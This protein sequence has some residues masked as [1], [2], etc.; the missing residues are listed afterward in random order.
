MVLFTAAHPHQRSTCKVGQNSTLSHLSIVPAALAGAQVRCDLDPLPAACSDG[1]NGNGCRQGL[2]RASD[3]SGVDLPPLQHAW[4]SSTTAGVGTS[5]R[6]RLPRG[7]HRPTGEPSSRSRVNHRPLRGSGSILDARA[8]PPDIRLS[9][10]YLR[11]RR[12]APV[13]RHCRV[14]RLRCRR[15]S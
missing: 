7:H 6:P 10:P 4:L 9:A 11:W 3:G 1:G 8:G 13:L 12:R 15:G 2:D 14:M 5:S